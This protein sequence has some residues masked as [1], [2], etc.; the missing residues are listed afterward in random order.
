MS[1]SVRRGTTELSIEGHGERITASRGCLISCG[2]HLNYCGDGR[3]RTFVLDIPV[4]S[5]PALR[6]GYSGP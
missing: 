3:D 5:L 4:V 2:R 6:D 1:R